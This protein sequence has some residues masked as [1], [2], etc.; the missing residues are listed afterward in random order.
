MGTPAIASE[1]VFQ[2]QNAALFPGANPSDTSALMNSVVKPNAPPATTATL[3]PSSLILQ[4]V[5]SQLSTEIYNGIF[6][7]SNA[8][9][10]YNLGGGNSI[11]FVRP[12]NGT[13]QITIDQDGTNTEITVPDD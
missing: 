5:E 7:T 2:G 11:S 3:S 9:G 8:S 13:I 10:T 4:S 1:L 6:N 12:G